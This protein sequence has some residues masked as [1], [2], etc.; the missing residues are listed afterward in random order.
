MR[1]YSLLARL[2]NNREKIELHLRSVKNLVELVQDQFCNFRKV[3]QTKLKLQKKT[4]YKIPNVD[5]VIARQRQRIRYE[6]S[7]CSDYGH[8]FTE[9]FEVSMKFSKS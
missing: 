1:N 5:E 7:T 6:Q 3:Y 2:V 4:E 8:M 9:T